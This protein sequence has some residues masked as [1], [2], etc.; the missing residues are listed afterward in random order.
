MNDYEAKKQARIDRY[1]DK[2]DKARAESRAC[3]FHRAR[4]SNACFWTLG[5]RRNG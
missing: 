4:G 2:A 3:S 1:R 5:Q